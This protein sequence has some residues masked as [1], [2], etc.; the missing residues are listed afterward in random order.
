[1]EYKVTIGKVEEITPYEDNARINDKAVEKV[2]QSIK[3]FG[4]QSPIV[5][6]ENNVILAGHSRHKAAMLLGLE[7]VPIKV[8]EGL[9]EDNKM[10]YRLMDN[11]SQDF[12]QWD[13][14]LLAQEFEKLSEKD[15]DMKLTGFEL[16]EISKIYSS[17][18]EF[19]MPEETDF[20][21]DVS[22]DFHVP[23]TN[24]KQFM[25]LY[26]VDQLIQLKENLDK[27]KD[28]YKLENYSDIVFEAVKN[29]AS[30]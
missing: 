6:D 28:L 22:D 1:M 26:D 11:K 12:A 24:I 23:E 19:D 13:N 5:V 18:L 30:K 4:W 29:E 7:E 20:D 16:D 3:E 8:A 9:S 21:I 14:G 17:F 10:A 27:L 25:L 2:A 15:F